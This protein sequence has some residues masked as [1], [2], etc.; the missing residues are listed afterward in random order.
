MN[1]LDERTRHQLLAREAECSFPGGIEQLEV[2]VEIEK[3]EH[4]DG[5]LE[6]TALRLANRNRSRVPA[7]RKLDSGAQLAVSERPDENDVRLGCIGAARGRLVLLIDREHDGVA[8]LRLLREFATRVTAKR[9][10]YE[11]DIGLQPRRSG[12]GLVA[13]KGDGR[14]LVSTAG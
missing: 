4:V 7:D 2:T 9:R 10:R 6:E 8:R 5:V 13:R 14:D 12:D 11:N 3:A 1:E